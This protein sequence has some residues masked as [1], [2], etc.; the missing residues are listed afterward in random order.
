MGGKR[1]HKM[2]KARCLAGLLFVFVVSS[3]VTL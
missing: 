1:L 3:I 2:Q